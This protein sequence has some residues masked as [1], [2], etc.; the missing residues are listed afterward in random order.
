[1]VSGGRTEQVVGRV[2][3]NCLHANLDGGV[4]NPV[5]FIIDVDV[6]HLKADEPLEWVRYRANYVDYSAD[7]S[8]YRLNCVP[9]RANK[10]D[11]IVVG[12]DRS[13]NRVD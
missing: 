11:F 7:S 10:C 1:M 2:T 9:S 12:V 6:G 4:T 8:P 5:V 13:V 3:L